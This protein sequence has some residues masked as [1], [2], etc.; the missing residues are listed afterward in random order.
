[1]RFAAWAV[2]GV[3][4]VG[5]AFLAYLTWA[6]TPRRV[7]S[8]PDPNAPRVK[9]R[10]AAGD[11]LFYQIVERRESDGAVYGVYLSPHEKPPLDERG[12]LV[13]QTVEWPVPVR[14]SRVDANT[15]EIELDRPPEGSDGTAVRITFNPKPRGMIYWERGRTTEP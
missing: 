4:A 6:F 10:G 3:F 9:V 2:I 12:D 7:A 11:G 15:V 8:G 5:A 1:M 13:L 14:V